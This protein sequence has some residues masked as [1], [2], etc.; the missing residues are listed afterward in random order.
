[1]FNQVVKS[2]F[3]AIL[4]SVMILTMISGFIFGQKAPSKGDAPS[5]LIADILK[6]HAK[7]IGASRQLIIVTSEGYDM[8]P[9]ETTALQ[10][11]DKGWEIVF[12]AIPSTLGKKG[13][14]K[15]GEKKE[16]DWKT[17]SGIYRIGIA[18]GYAPKMETAI[19]YR[20]ATENDVWVDDVQSPQYNTWVHG[21]PDAKS[22]EKMKRKDHLYKMGFV[23]EYNTNPIVKGDGSAIFFHVW[24]RPGAF[25]AGC[26]A[27]AEEDI[28]KIIRFLD[29]K[30]NPMVI[31]GTKDDILKLTE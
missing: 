18:F 23:V 28:A 2:Y 21:T 10:K 11:T 12:N 19:P 20:Q 25:T 17:P 15:P 6:I 3:I 9:A 27:M 24:R 16:G 7:E 8:V 13:F 4:Y 22:F 29:P 1:M 31:M 5:G 26:V 30:A 14:A